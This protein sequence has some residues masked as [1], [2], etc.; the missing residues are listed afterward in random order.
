VRRVAPVAAAIGLLVTSCG[1][2]AAAPTFDAEALP[3]GTPV[4][5]DDIDGEPV[6]LAAFATWCLP[7]ERELPALDAVAGEWAAMGVQVVAVNVDDPA[8]DDGAVLAMV[9]RLDVT[10]PVW[11]D[12]DLAFLTTFD[13]TMMPFSVL[14]DR[15]GAIVR[16]WTGAVDPD[17]PDVLD[18]IERAA[19]A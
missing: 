12:R 9:D 11:R 1:G 6:L 17:S 19:A 18:A 5:L 7:C 14:L 16:T 15:D 2:G 4:S 8:T 10:L 3:G 13:G